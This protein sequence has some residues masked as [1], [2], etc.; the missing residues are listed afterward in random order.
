MREPCT[1]F[2]CSI[3]L[4]LFQNKKISFKKVG[5]GEGAQVPALVTL[6]HH[7]YGACWKPLSEQLFWTQLIQNPEIHETPFIEQILCVRA[8]THRF[9][10]HTRHPASTVS[11]EALFRDE[12]TVTQWALKPAEITRPEL[13]SPGLLTPSPGPSGVL[14]LALGS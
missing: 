7:F 2:N 13:Q 14:S 10:Q 12:E 5:T 3:S 4:K 11:I 9:T 8:N 6:A 1:I